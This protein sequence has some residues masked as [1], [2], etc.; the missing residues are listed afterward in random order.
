MNSTAL[1][2]LFKTVPKEQQE[3]LLTFRATHQAKK[4]I[5]G[6]VEWNYLASGQA[7]ETILLLTGGLN[8]YDAGFQIISDFE[9]SYRVLA[10]RYPDVATV[11][12]LVEGVVALLDAEQVQRV[13]VLGQ[14]LGGMVAQCLVRRFPDRVQ[15]LVLSSTAAP[16]KGLVAHMKRQ[17]R[18]VALF[19]K[20][21]LR[22][23][24][25]R[26]ILPMLAEVPVEER[27]FW[28][29]FMREQIALYVTKTWLLC[30][31]KLLADYCANYQF[32]AD[33][34]ANWPGSILIL[35][36]D[37]DELIRRLARTPLTAFY[38]QARV[39]MLHQAGHVLLITRR[40]EYIDVVKLFLAEG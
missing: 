29:A 5:V 22:P 13:H 24:S 15:T 7:A 20:W 19:P 3:Q 21:L 28:T 38:P 30:Q 1:D 40:Q 12:E 31:Y 26:R 6:G 39:Y 33:D 23:V 8:T 2:T 37:D 25:E 32:A 34:L 36:A 11:A 9:Q 35:Q 4:L 27:A 18:L 14:S 17:E 16:D 10:I